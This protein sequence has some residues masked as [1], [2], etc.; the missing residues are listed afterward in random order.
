MIDIITEAKFK[1]IDAR[2]FI[3]QYTLFKCFIIFTFI[4]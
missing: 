4:W 1:T 3:Y 2:L